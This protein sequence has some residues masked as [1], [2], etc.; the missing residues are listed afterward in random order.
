M[1]EGATPTAGDTSVT[2]KQAAIQFE[3]LMDDRSTDNEP[4]KE[5]EQQRQVEMV[6]ET[7]EQI[8]DAPE[9]AEEVIEEQPTHRIKVKNIDG[10]MEEKDVTLDELLHG[11][12]RMSDYTRKTIKIAEKAKAVDEKERQYNAG[13]KAIEEAKIKRDDYAQRL[14]AMNEYLEQG[15]P[16]SE[17]LS[18]LR[19]TDPTAY[20][21]AVSDKFLIQ[22]KQQKML[23]EADRI[24]R[25]QQAEHQAQY[26]QLLS[27]EQQKLASALPDYADAEKGKQLR[28]DIKSYGKKVGFTDQELGSVVDSRMVQVLHKAMLLDKLEQ[29]NPEVQKRVQKAPKMLKAGTRASSSNAVE[30]TKKL[31]AQLRKSGNTR[32]A[33]AVFE[34]IL[35]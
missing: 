28:A 10:K 11:Y 3:G 9:E 24:A 17:E 12:Q 18:R 32:D 33:Q 34:R 2:V 8:A 29:S 15:Q 19:E 5:E 20:N 25:E 35:G 4:P 30:Q 26:Q 7:E 14:V 27:Q 1:S 16:S 23:A 13:I 22:E 21:K 6:E 31:K